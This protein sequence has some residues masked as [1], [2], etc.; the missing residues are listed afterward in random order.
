MGLC[1]IKPQAL[2]FCLSNISLLLIVVVTIGIGAVTAAVKPTQDVADP[3]LSAASFSQR[4]LLWDYPLNQA[5][6]GWHGTHN[7]SIR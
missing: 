5:F 4:A 6:S 3:V 7:R 1:S 2:I